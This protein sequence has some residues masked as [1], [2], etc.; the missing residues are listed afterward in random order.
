[1]SNCVF[2]FV[3]L[4]GFWILGLGSLENSEICDLFFCALGSLVLNS[5]V[6]LGCRILCFP[7][8]VFLGFGFEGLGRCGIL[9]PFS[10]PGEDFFWKGFFLIFV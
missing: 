1:M 7:L 3:G 6:G 10:P 5:L 9:L 8:W 4:A 2:S